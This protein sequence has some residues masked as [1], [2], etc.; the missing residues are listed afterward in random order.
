MI[1]QGLHDEIFQGS[2][3]VL[4]GVD[5]FSTYC[6]LLKAAEHRDEETWGWYLLE[7]QAR[8]FDPDNTI[9]D[10]AK[11]LR[12]GQKAVLSDTPCHGDVFS[13]FKQFKDFVLSLTR[14]V[15]RATSSRVDQEEDIVRAQLAQEPT[16]SMTSKWV[17]LKRR[18]K[19]LLTLLIDV[20]ILF[21]WM[22]HDVLKLA[23]PTLSVRQELFDFI[24]EELQQRNDGEFPMLRKLLKALHNQRDQL[25]A[26]SGV[27]D[28]KPAE[29]SKRLDVPLA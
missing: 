18:E 4:T 9:A 7:I 27:L 2:L 26:F 3:A 29:I 13:I 10:V 14:K 5:A 15:Q 6:Y 28:Q 23:G 17:H 12:A 22:V 20:K 19:R 21:Q 1:K 16:R 11:G 8:G 25:L 24:K